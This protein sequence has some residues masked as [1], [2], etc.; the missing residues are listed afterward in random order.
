MEISHNSRRMVTSFV[1]IVDILIVILFMFMKISNKNNGDDISVMLF[2]FVDLLFVGYFLLRII[3]QFGKR[4]SHDLVIIVIEIVALYESI[5]GIFQIIGVIKSNNY[6][7]LCTGTFDNPGPLGGFLAICISIS[8]AVVHEKTVNRGKKPCSTFDKMILMMSYLSITFCTI[9]I[10]STQSR[11]ALLSI[12][13]TSFIY[14]SKESIIRSWIINHLIFF[15]I[16]I[17]FLMSLVLI[18]K[19][20]SL[21]GRLITYKM[22]LMTIIRNEYK[23]VGLGHFS[24]AY[25]KT[26]RDYFSKSIYINEGDLIYSESDKERIFADNPKVGFNDYLQFGIEFGVGPLILL[27]LFIMLIGF[28]LF[29][30][31]SPL[32]QG[33]IS[34]IVFASFSYPFSIWAFRLL[35]I[36]FAAYAGSEIRVNNSPRGCN[37]FFALIYIVPLAIFFGSI[38]V[39]R[40]I[41]Q[42]ETKWESQRFIFGNGDYLSYEY[43][44]SQLYPNMKHNCAFLYEYAYSLY[45][46]RDLVGSETIVN[47]SLTLSGNALLF[48]L[49]G[50]IHKEMGLIKEAEKDYLDS[51][52]AIPDRLYPMYKLAVLYHD[53]NQITNYH[54]TVRSIDNFHPRIESQATNDIRDMLNELNDP[55]DES[56]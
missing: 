21:N 39:I 31:D 6:L 40:T 26:Q 10:P 13:F 25:G 37:L 14:L 1:S 18:F 56:M 12:I 9:L 36:V 41:H 8:I 46:N 35:F 7:F 22:E 19:R 47:Q 24:N 32:C 17:I 20:P 33:L 38:E 3:F 55:N 27:L 50:D 5:L 34:L 4:I 29:K 54:N 42:Y 48:I 45:M 49:L 2:S 52:F 11:A 43:C 44:C 15:I 28:R 23:G 53:S 51:F 16:T 30:Y